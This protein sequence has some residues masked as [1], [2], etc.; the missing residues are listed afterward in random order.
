VS[1]Q[2]L[3]LRPTHFDESPKFI[4]GNCSFSFLTLPIPFSFSCSLLPTYTG[5]S[6]RPS[7]PRSSASLTST[8]SSV[9]RPVSATCCFRSQEGQRSELP[10]VLQCVILYFVGLTSLYRSVLTLAGRDK[11]GYYHELF[12]R[13]KRF[14]SHRIQRIKI[15]GTG[16]RK[17]S[18][19][20]TEPNF[21]NAPFL[22]STS[23]PSKN[24]RV[25]MMASAPNMYPDTGGSLSL[26]QLL[27]FPAY[28]APLQHQTQFAPPPLFRTSASLFME[29][30]Y[31][32]Q[33]QAQLQQ[34]LRMVPSFYPEMHMVAGFGYPIPM[35]S[36]PQNVSGAAMALAFSRDEHDQAALA[37]SRSLYRG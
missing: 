8:D 3:E 19:P 17:P 20:E 26:H 30:Q 33:A 36:G 5:G 1:N 35:V 12:L 25:S 14:L 4:V 13:N 15:K 22:P 23:L 9:L 2:V 29:A 37:R 24:A 11:G 7:F 10:Y 18:S 27:A 6:A 28:G 32:A 34:Q 31:K 16:A 21:Y